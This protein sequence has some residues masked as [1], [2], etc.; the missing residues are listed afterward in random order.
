M[1]R[2]LPGVPASHRHGHRSIRAALAKNEVLELQACHPRFFATHRYL[3][4]ARLVSVEPRGGV[5][6]KVEASG[7]VAAAASYRRGGSTRR[8]R[9]RRLAVAARH[10]H[11][12]IRLRGSRDHVRLLPRQ[13]LEHDAVSIQA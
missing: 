11:E 6:Y 13:R 3:V 8:A 1:R 5:P 7:T 10:V 9:P 2:C 4:Y 12:R